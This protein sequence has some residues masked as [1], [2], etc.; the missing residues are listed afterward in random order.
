[1]GSRYASFDNIVWM[2]GNDYGLPHAD[3]DAAND[4]LV[5]A[6]ALGIRDNDTRHL[7][8][9]EFNTN[10]NLP[11]VLSTDDS[12][13]LPIIDLNAAYTYQATYAA[14][15][16]GYNSSNILPVFMV[17]S[18]YEFESI[19]VF[20]SAPRNLRAQEYW[21]NLSGATGQ[22]YGNGYTWHFA[23]DWKQQ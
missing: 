19:A 2:H 7:H 18:G 9:V 16:A 5:T 21:S 17:E 14:V 10:T 6:I 23:S 12:R 1:L 13:W 8:T 11:P 20:G 22:L 15:L 4:A 3:H